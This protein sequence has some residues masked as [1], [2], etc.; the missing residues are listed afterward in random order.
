[1]S[2]AV[3]A[4]GYT[5]DGQAEDF[6]WRDGSVW[7]QS[8]HNTKWCLVGCSIGDFGTI[9]AF[10]FIPYLDALGWSTMSIMLLAMFNGI[11]TS[12]ALETI[13]LSAQMALKEAFRVAI[14]M[15][16]I[17]MISMEAAMNIVDVVLTGGA[18]LTLW[19]I[20][21]MLVAGFLTPWPYNYW[22][23]KKYGMACH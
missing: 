12:I 5:V 17:S 21:P 23:L 2:G 6:H 3:R 7:R 19:V 10:Q 15:S 18:K 8:A 14:G 4:I 1:M 11:M 13:I 20:I 16:L 9:A 22:R